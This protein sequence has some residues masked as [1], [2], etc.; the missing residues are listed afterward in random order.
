[1]NKD[2]QVQGM[3]QLCATIVV[4]AGFKKLTTQNAAKS[5]ES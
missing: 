1:M 5:K 3:T 4:K 2:V